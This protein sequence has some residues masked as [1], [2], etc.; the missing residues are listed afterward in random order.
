M[1]SSSSASSGSGFNWNGSWLD[2]Q[3]Y[4]T[5]EPLSQKVR[6]ALAPSQS[7]RE[8][9]SSSSSSSSSKGKN[10]NENG[11]TAA[12][13]ATWV[14]DGGEKD[15]WWWGVRASSPLPWEQDQGGQRS[16][17]GRGRDRSGSCVGEPGQGGQYASSA[18]SAASA[19]RYSPSRHGGG[20]N[21]GG[22]GGGGGNG[23]HHERRHDE[24]FSRYGDD[25]SRFQHPQ[26]R[27]PDRS[28]DREIRR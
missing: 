25:R 6:E 16:S 14:G 11:A 15:A 18:S 9:L 20:G 24:D 21:G 2:S 3:C 4:R 1:P 26:R 17:S 23:R 28:Y 19:Y 8:D 10:G 13:A 27:S 12:S 22:D 5:M 7:S